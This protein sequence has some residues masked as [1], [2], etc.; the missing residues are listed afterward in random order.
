M[1]SIIISETTM[2]LLARSSQQQEGRILTTSSCIRRFDGRW[3]C[4]IEQSTIDR[5]E[6]Y[7]ADG[8]SMEA[9]ILR[10]MRKAGV[11]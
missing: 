2:R 6:K 4:P 7:R 8:E 3:E 9:V 1:P 11:M 5:L 10:V